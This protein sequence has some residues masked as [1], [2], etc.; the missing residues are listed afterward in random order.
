MPVYYVVTGKTLDEMATYL[1]QTLDELEKISGF[2]K[3]KIENY[4]QQFLDIITKYSLG[5][6]L[7]SQI[8]NKITQRG[9]VRQA[10]ALWERKQIP[11][12]PLLNFSK[13]V[14]LLPT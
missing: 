1:P 3:A 6:G 11:K 14:S 2:G 5:Q 7:A 4:G 13:L 9:N 12:P 10:T 8:H